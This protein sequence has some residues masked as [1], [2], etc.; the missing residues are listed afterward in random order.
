MFIFEGLGFGENSLVA[1]KSL[2]NRCPFLLMNSLFERPAGK[3]IL[4][5][6]L[7]HDLLSFQSCF[8]ITDLSQMQSPVTGWLKCCRDSQFCTAH[9]R[10]KFGDQNISVLKFVNIFTKAVGLILKSKVLFST[11]EQSVTQIVM[12]QRMSF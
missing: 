11:Q 7:I 5:L 12:N 4:L 3:I 10:Y 6:F 8:T 9:I 2:L 1:S